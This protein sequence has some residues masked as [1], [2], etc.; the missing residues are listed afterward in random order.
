MTGTKIQQA[1]SAI[2]AGAPGLTHVVDPD[3]PFSLTVTHLWTAAGRDVAEYYSYEDG[4]FAG[5]H[6]G[7]WGGFQYPFEDLSAFVTALMIY[8]TVDR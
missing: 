6:V 2:E 7:I 1:R 8:V 3:S 4:S 5:G